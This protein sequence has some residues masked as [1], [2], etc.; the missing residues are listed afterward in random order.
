M[1]RKKVNDNDVKKIYHVILYVEKALRP[2]LKEQGV[3]RKFLT[4][5]ITTYLYNLTKE[6]IITGFFT[7]PFR[8][9]VLQIRD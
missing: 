7:M 3:D 5:I 4:K 1:I 9:G 2:T 6:F 8:L